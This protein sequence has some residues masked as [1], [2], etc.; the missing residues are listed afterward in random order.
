MS[1]EVLAEE[2]E[3]LESI[4]PAE[5]TKLSEREIQIDVEPDDPVDGIEELSLTFS[6]EYPDEYPDTLPKL[7]L[8]VQQGELD[9]AEI[10][11]LL[12]ELQKVGEENLGMA[13]TFTLVTHL[14]ER[15]SALQRE[16]LERIRKEEAEKERRALEAEEAKTRGTPVTA[17]SFKAW[18]AKFDKEMAVKR[19]RE[20]EE[21]LKGLS[22]KEREEYKKSQTRFTGR[23]LFE[24]DR[25]LGTLD[26]GLAE[27]DAVSV[28]IS[29][30]DRN[31]IEEE[32]NEE[33]RVTFSDSD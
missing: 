5:L 13:M 17:E 29:Q 18:K 16:R 8:E 20:E 15:L 7:S 33:D 21:K 19:A 25:N 4:Y 23:Q 11:Q 3:V 31:A 27:E 22:P 30:Y 32:E 2:F 9:D 12:D 24:R 14:R 28:D 26:E 1:A 10:S 6:V